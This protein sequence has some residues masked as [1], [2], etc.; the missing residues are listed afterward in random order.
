M[1]R[2]L[3]ALRQI[4]NL[5]YIPAR[6]LDGIVQLEA[7]GVHPK[8]RSLCRE[9]IIEMDRYPV[10]D[11]LPFQEESEDYDEVDNNSVIGEDTEINAVVDVTE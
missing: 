4:A 10:K 3:D 2:A 9:A 8:I 7:S 11:D 1:S 5:P 6:G